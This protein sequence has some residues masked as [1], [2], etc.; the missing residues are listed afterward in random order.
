MVIYRVLI[1]WTGEIFETSS[2]KRAY[3]IAKREAKDFVRGSAMLAHL[4]IE[5]EV[6]SCSDDTDDFWH[7]PIKSVIPVFMLDAV[8][9]DCMILY[10][11]RDKKYFIV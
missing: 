9:H 7:F 1:P 2:T 4:V 8:K 5:K 3:Q 10:R 11:L 6:Y